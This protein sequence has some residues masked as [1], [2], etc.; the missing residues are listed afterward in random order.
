LKERAELK[1]PCREGRKPLKG[2]CMPPKDLERVKVDDDFIKLVKEE[3]ERNR[4]LLERLAK[5]S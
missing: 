2:D 3:I 1:K 4:D 5:N